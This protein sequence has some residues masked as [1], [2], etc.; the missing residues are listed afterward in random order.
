[1]QIVS[2]QA[3]KRVGFSGRIIIIGSFGAS[4]SLI[5]GL[6]PLTIMFFALL[7]INRKLKEKT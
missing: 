2:Y 6:L 4:F 3:L 5:K 1:M 7:Y